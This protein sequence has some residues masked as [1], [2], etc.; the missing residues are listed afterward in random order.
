MNL[1]QYL[2]EYRKE[3]RGGEEVIYGGT[4][5]TA[6]EQE[7]LFIFEKNKIKINNKI[8]KKMKMK[9][10]MKKGRVE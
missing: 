2:V 3:G 7:Y 8:K 5:A 4:A 6:A 10:G 1:P 9:E